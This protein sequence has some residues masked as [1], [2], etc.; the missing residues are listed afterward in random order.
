MIS[1]ISKVCEDMDVRIV[2]LNAQENKDETYR[3]DMKLM[4]HDKSQVEKICRS[5]K[6]IQGILEAYRI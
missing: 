2:G 4:I 3:I 1:N 6:N 5:F